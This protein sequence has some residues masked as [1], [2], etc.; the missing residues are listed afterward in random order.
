MPNLTININADLL[1]QTKIYA[2]SQGISLNQM[3]KEYLGEITKRVPKTQNSDQVRTI[4][5]RYSEDKLSR[6]ETMALLGVDYGELILMMADN[7]MPLP[8]L[9]EPEITEMA[10]MFSKIWRSSQ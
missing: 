7:L 8:T 10:T 2:A 4:L 3:I 6:K 1:H 9:P 5:K